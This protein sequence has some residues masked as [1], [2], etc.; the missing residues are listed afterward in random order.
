MTQ[1]LETTL[2]TVGDIVRW[3]ASRLN[4][5][6]RHFGHGTDNAADESR[7]L[8]FH[9]L[10]LDFEVPAYFYQCRV[11]AAERAAAVALIESRIETGRPAAYLT[12]EAWFAGLR[13]EVDDA[14]LVPRSPIAE[15]IA[16]GF[17]AWFGPQQIQRA[18]DVGTGSGC[19]ACALAA[20]IGCRVD[21]T[22]ISPAALEVA[23]RNVRAHNLDE[24]IELQESDVYQALGGRRYDLIVSNP[25]YVSAT[26]M[27]ALPDEYGHEPDIA[28]R[29]G[30]NG[31][32]ILER[33]LAG[34]AAHLNPGGILICEAGEA[35]QALAE[36]YPEL[37]FEWID[38]EH[39]GDGVFVLQAQDLERHATGTRCA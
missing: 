1:D 38:F 9:A 12:G 14:V 17:S 28:L 5:S 10:A 8:V 6:G 22:D 31:L 18:L 30:A 35:A 29:A 20:H 4:E 23:R 2:L 16:D 33:L 34:A 26:S 7:V 13:F 27:A 32:E 25:P 11:T 39:G 37:P 3:G 36:R 15:L 21:A 19:I 24:L